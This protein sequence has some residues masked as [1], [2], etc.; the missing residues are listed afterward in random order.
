MKVLMITSEWPTPNHPEW[1]PFLVREVQQLR[2]Q[3]LHLDIFPF[4]GNMRPANYVAAWHALQQRVVDHAYDLIHAQFGQSALLAVVP[5]RLPLVVTFRGS[6]LNGIIGAQGRLTLAGRMLRYLSQLVSLRADEII[7]VA[8]K[9]AAAL[10]RKRYHV[11]PS[12]L[13]LSLFHPVSQQEARRQLNLCPDYH[14][15]LF[16]ASRRN[17]IKRYALAKA[18]TSI[19]ESERPVE[20]L[21]VEG[22]PPNRVPLYMNAADVL[23]LTSTREGSPNVVKEALACNL[24]VVSVDV[25]DVRERLQGVGGC[26]VT[27]DDRAETI[28]AA[29]R[30]VLRRGQR[31]NGRETVRHL[32]LEM[33][34]QRIIDVYRQALSL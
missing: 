6:D 33:T 20:L 15:V 27:E 1:V 10:P 8:R 26:R 2:N 5:K 25:G 19:I 17:P 4:Q 28:A 7:L 21:V 12:G 29:L 9:L 14:Y 34:A 13:D 11:I 31:V 3:G 30:E 24:P 32:S 22:E 16:V 23:V 18:A